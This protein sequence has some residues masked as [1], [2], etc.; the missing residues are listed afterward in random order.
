MRAC[1]LCDVPRCDACDRV[2]CGHEND[3]GAYC[4]CQCPPADLRPLDAV[5][6]TA[7]C[8]L[9]KETLHASVIPGHKGTATLD[10]RDEHE[11]ERCIETWTREQHIQ[12][13]NDCADAFDLLQHWFRSGSLGGLT[14]CGADIYAVYCSDDIHHIAT[15]S[16]CEA[17]RRRDLLVLASHPPIHVPVP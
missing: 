13:Q 6:V 4:V 7:P 14:A 12:F 3:T 11:H 8:P 5:S 17:E 16:I 9:C 1:P 2:T 15:C 10:T